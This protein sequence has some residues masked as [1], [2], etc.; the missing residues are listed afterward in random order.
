MPNVF[1][2]AV[3]DASTI[4]EAFEAACR[5]PDGQIRAGSRVAVK[6]H[7]G[8]ATNTRF[9]PPL[10]IRPVIESLKRRTPDVFL[11]DTNTL[12]RGQRMNATDHRK[13]ALAHGFGDLGVPVVI[14]DGEIG[15]E[16]VVITVNR[17]IFASIRIARAIAEADTVIA[18]SHFKGHA[19]FGFGGAVKNIGMGCG[20]RAG[21]LAMHTRLGLSVGKGCT[22]CGACIEQCAAGAIAIRG[23]RAV[24]DEHR[25]LHCA[26]CIAV[27]DQ[28]A[29]KIPWGSATGQQVQE[30]CAEYAY[31]ALFGKQRVFLTFINNVSR[32]CDCR[33]DTPLI[34]SDIGL[35]ASTDPVACDQ[36][37]YDLFVEKNGS[38]LERETG[39]DGR[40]ILDYAERIGLGK[41]DYRLIHL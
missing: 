41:R 27:C 5:C 28:K 38:I 11:T 13:L 33:P 34:G 2:S 31:G 24:I 22:A 4:G 20:S 23:E 17:P 18:V 3:I 8:E 10:Q 39:A 35:V 1:F 6:V 36:A 12:Y 37:A 30:R 7:F 9:I 40:P 29:I 32:D 14:A 19:L 15:E 25:C 21:K 16:E 26:A